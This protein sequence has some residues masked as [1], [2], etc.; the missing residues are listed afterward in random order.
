MTNLSGEITAR[1]GF[2]DIEIQPLEDGN[3]KLVDIRYRQGGQHR[4][5]VLRGY[6]EGVDRKDVTAETAWLSALAA[7]TDLLVPSPIP[8]LDGTFI[9]DIDLGPES[10]SNA[11][12]LQAWLHRQIN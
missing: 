2:F 8:A 3:Q 4:R 9:Q 5:A 10:R 1:Y 7:D 12:V 11:A 6:Y